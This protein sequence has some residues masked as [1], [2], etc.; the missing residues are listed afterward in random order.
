[1]KKALFIFSF[2][3]LTSISIPALAQ[4]DDSRIGLKGGLNLSTLYTGDIEDTDPRVG[5]HVGIF[6]ELAVS[7]YFSLQPELLLSTK[8]NV[9]TY[10]IDGPANIINAEGEAEISFAYLELPILAKIA[11]L[12]VINIHAGPY[13]GYMVD[14]NTS[15]EGDVAGN[16]EEDINRDHFNNW[17]VGVAVGAGVDLSAVTIGARYSWGLV[18]VAE[19]E[20]AKLLLGSG[21]NAVLQ[22][23]IAIGF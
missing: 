11:I 13:I 20:A 10:D 21:K 8:G 22:G 6:T 1:M 23:Y 15:L 4:M 19:S 5:Y 17:D 18:E 16:F 9:N 14:A 2:L 3:L 7:E 12:E